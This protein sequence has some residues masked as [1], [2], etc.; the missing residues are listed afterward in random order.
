MKSTQDILLLFGRVALGLPFLAAGL[1]QVET[2]PGTAGLFRHA[3]APYP[4]ALAGAL[5]VVNL[6][7]PVLFILGIRA[8]QAALVLAATTA[9]ALYLLHRIDLGAED[10]QRSAAIIGGLLVLGATGPGRHAM[11]PGE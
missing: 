11:Q 4:L 7:A 8:R 2:W 5:V 1:R 9:V 10:F 6:A 3:G